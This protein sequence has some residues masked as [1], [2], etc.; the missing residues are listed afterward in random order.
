MWPGS[1]QSVKDAETTVIKSSYEPYEPDYVDGSPT[2]VAIPVGKVLIAHSNIVHRGCGFTSWDDDDTDHEGTADGGAQSDG[3]DRA[4]SASGRA[5]GVEK[6]PPRGGDATMCGLR[7]V[8]EMSRVCD[9]RLEARSGRESR[10]VR[11]GVRG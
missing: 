11:G 4:P 3:A 5:D 7:G 2:M 8:V 1:H 9:T 10:S 6:A